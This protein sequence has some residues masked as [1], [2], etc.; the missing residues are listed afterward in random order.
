MGTATP[1]AL[2]VLQK[3]DKDWRVT[4]TAVCDAAH[5]QLAAA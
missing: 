1:W 4:K 2:S 3:H 5:Y